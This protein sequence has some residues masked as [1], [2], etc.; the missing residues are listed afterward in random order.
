MWICY[1]ITH[2]FDALQWMMMEEK[3]IK[4]IQH[5]N[6]FLKISSESQFLCNYLP[7][8]CS[9]CTIVPSNEN[10]IKYAITSQVLSYLNQQK[11]FD[12]DENPF[13]AHFCI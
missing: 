10:S 13:R 4:M 2:H 3:L 7:A 8:E 1:C 9:S 5:V 6:I 12:I 11:H